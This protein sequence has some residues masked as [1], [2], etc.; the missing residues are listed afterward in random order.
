MPAVF[1]VMNRSVRL[2]M[3]VHEVVRT[4]INRS[5]ATG[6]SSRSLAENA[7]RCV[8]IVEPTRRDIHGR[9]SGGFVHKPSHV[10]IRLSPHLPRCR[11]LA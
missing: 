11:G 9:K 7:R 8:G 6:R 1:D 5:E 4:G 10:P 3:R 2:N